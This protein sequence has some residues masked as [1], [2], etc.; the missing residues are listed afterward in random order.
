MR[1]LLLAAALFATPVIASPRADSKLDKPPAHCNSEAAAS[2]LLGALS[3]EVK[4]TN[5]RL[6]TRDQTNKFLDYLHL[7]PKQIGHLPPIDQAFTVMPPGK[8]GM[9]FLLVGIKYHG[10]KVCYN[11]V[12]PMPEEI[13]LEAMKAA[14][15][16]TP[17]IKGTGI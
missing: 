4:G 3:A 11:G 6:M 9:P 16:S 5:F 2:K 1:A 14:L 17:E 10:G 12:L 15:D 8:A 7:Y 13:W